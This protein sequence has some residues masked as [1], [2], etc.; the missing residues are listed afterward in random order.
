MRFR[1]EGN[2]NFPASLI[3]GGEGVRGRE[4]DSTSCRK[5]K[6]TL[7]PDKIQTI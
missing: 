1:V 2:F 4:E 6:I 5:G 7:E 3:E